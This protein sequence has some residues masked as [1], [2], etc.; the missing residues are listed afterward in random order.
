MSQVPTAEGVVDVGLVGRT[1]ERWWEGWVVEDQVCRLEGT[2][3][4][5]GPLPV[6]GEGDHACWQAEEDCREVEVEDGAEARATE[7]GNA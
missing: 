2:V 5:D 1:R 4:S 3:W 7:K 6:E